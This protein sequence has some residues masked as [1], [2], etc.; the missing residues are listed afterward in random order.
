MT[1]ETKTYIKLNNVRL[2]FPQVFEAKAFQGEGAEMYS[3]TFLIDPKTK[4][5]KAIIKELEDEMVRIAKDK[6]G[7]KADGVMK[8][9][10][11]A[12]KTCLH[13]GDVKD[14]YDGFEGMMYVSAR[15]KT[16]PLVLNRDKTPLSAQDGIPY[17]GC[18]VNTSVNLWAQDNGFGKRINAGLRGIQFLRDGDAFAGAAPAS[19]D[20]FDSVDESESDLA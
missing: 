5:G 12:D 2:A 8:A 3:A 14:G 18:Y 19:E 10:K 1:E 11:N 13:N 7:A 6:W 15:N 17:A 4:E 20:E 16:R 9:M